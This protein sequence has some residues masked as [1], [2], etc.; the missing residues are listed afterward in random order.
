MTKLHDENFYTYQYDLLK[1]ENFVLQPKL[2]EQGPDQ[3]GGSSPWSGGRHTGGLMLRRARDS[4]AD[5][6]DVPRRPDPVVWDPPPANIP[7][8]T[9]MPEGAEN[10][11]GAVRSWQEGIN[12]LQG[13][14]HNRAGFLFDECQ[15]FGIAYF[16]IVRKISV[17][18]AD[19][20]ARVSNVLLKIASDLDPNPQPPA[21]ASARGPA[22]YAGCSKFGVRRLPGT[23]SIFLIGLRQSSPQR[24]LR[25][26]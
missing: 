7:P 1:D 25:S 18:G 3:P 23:Y 17:T 19:V 11:L 2:I 26:D 14:R 12:E 20:R 8:N 4:E 24:M 15:Q 21:N 5:L 9:P 10:W 6:G 16:G 13:R 22:H